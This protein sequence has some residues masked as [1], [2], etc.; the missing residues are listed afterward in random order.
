M[1]K[2]QKKK[3]KRKNKMID[4]IIG[5]STLIQGTIVATDTMRID[6]RVNGKVKSECDVIVGESGNVDGD[7]E[8]VDVLVAGM[9]SGSLHIRERLEIT[10][11][12]KIRGDIFTKTLV[13]DEGASFK[14]NCSMDLK[15]AEP[16]NQQKSNGKSQDEKKPNGRDQND[17]S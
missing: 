11:T 2:S 4:T 5:Q 16:G 3:D 6:G 14:G 9:V 15:E 10:P 7:I 17:K 12:G 8:A 13:V 1:F